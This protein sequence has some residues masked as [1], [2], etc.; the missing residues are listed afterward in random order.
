MLVHTG[1]GATYAATQMFYGRLCL[2]QQ[3][4]AN[5]FCM[6]VWSLGKRVQVYWPA[7]IENVSHIVKRKIRPWRPRTLDQLQLHIKREWER[8]SL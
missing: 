1:F 7:C 5:M 6:C 4:N 3:D 8:F 2:F